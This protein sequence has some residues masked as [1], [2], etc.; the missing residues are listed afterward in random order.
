[1]KWLKL[2]AGSVVLA[3]AAWW[4]AQR[5]FVSEETRIRRQISMM[6]RAVER[7][8]WL[9]LEGGLAGDY[10]DD[11]GFDKSTLLVAARTFRQQYAS[12]FI[13]I[14]DLRVEVET[15][16]KK[17]TAVFIAKVIAAPRAG[18]ETEARAERVR[19]FFRKTDDGWKVTRL[20]S[21]EL[22]FE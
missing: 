4:L 15:D 14:T 7:G 3:L 12:I 5:V 19:L 17:A 1:M 21:P 16:E 11:L 2:L 9:R 18:G 6:E 8:D 13:H 22:K 20:E 10:S